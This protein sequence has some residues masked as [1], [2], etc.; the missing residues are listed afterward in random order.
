LTSPL[1]FRLL[2]VRSPRSRSACVKLLPAIASLAH[3]LISI[4]LNVLPPSRG[5]KFSRTP[6]PRSSVDTVAV[7]TAISAKTAMFG[8][9]C[10]FEPVST[11]EIDTPLRNISRS[12]ARLPCT[13]RPPP[14][15]VGLPLLPPTSTV[16]LFTPGIIAATNDG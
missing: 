1:L 4:P 9:P 14:P 8:T 2:G 5:M 10:V 6:D 13:V 3:E 15:V 12:V 11:V 16:L 7:S